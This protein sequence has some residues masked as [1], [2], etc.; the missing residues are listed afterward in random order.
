MKSGNR[1][2]LGVPSADGNKFLELDYLGGPVID[3]IYQDV[4]TEADKIYQ[5]TFDVRSRS[6]D[7]DTDDEAVVV[8]WNGQK[9]KVDGYRAAAA[10]E[11]T[12]ISVLVSGTGWT[13]SFDTARVNDTWRQ[14][15]RRP[16]P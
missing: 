10:G 2:F 11:W 5:L 9:T 14:Q 7:F 3:A 12:T 16:I 4:Q 6:S 1:E 13:G 8:E 15:R